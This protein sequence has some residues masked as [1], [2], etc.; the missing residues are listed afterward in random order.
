[1]DP[2]VAAAS[3]G[4]P[5]PAAKPMAIAVA[6]SSSP[7]P[8]SSAAA[9]AACDRVRARQGLGLAGALGHPQLGGDEIAL[10]RRE[11]DE[12]GHAPGH[13]RRRHHRRRDADHDDEDRVPDRAAHDAAQRTVGEVAEPRIDTAAQR[14]G[15]AAGRVAARIAEPDMRQVLGQDQE[16]FDQRQRQHV[17]HHRRHRPDERA[18]RRGQEQQ[19]HE[20][21]DRRHDREQDRPPDPQDAA[22]GR[23]VGPGAVLFQFGID[24][25][26]HYDGVIDHDSQRQDEP[27]EREL[28][29]GGAEELHRR[30]DAGEGD[31]HASRHPRRDAQ[32]EKQQE[33]REDQSRADGAVLHQKVDPALKLLVRVFPDYGGDARGQAVGQLGVQVALH[34]VHDVQ[35]LL[36]PHA[37]D[38]HEHRRLARDRG[39]DVAFG[40]TI[41]HLRDVAQPDLRAGVA[42]EQQL[43]AEGV[44]GLRLAQHA[45]L[46]IALPGVEPPRGQVQVAAPDAVGQVGQPDAVVGEAVA[47]Y[48]D[49]DLVGGHA[50]DLDL[51]DALPVGQ[52][53]AHLLG[54]RLERGADAVAVEHQLDGQFGGLDLGDAGLQGGVGKGGDA[55]DVGLDVVLHRTGVGPA[56]QLGCDHAHPAPG[57]GL[58]LAHALQPLKLFLDGREDG[59]G[60]LGGRGAGI[61]HGDRDR[62][63]GDLGEGADGQV[64]AA[65]TPAATSAAI[66]R[67]PATALCRNQRIRADINRPSA[68]RATRFGNSGHVRA[69]PV[70]RR[71]RRPGR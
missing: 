58:Q 46:E 7:A 25:L 38:R 69:A 4:P 64:N 52:V 51:A 33:H 36:G 57:G 62:A 63:G 60:H 1:M 6:R 50:R 30:E 16:A 10:D 45:Q 2:P 55:R 9:R 8:I 11:E 35:H 44:G 22:L 31:H 15:R 56:G 41:G 66:S 61:G 47:R 29:D 24:V 19:R 68:R 65:A 67:F 23:L 43:V 53:A 40:E 32:V 26:A 17:D 59:V 12:A 20:G 27:E 42:G 28:V 37:V 49:V 14:L 54:Q 70:C 5:P 18:R 71:R 34:L 3:P 48:G 21:Q 13:Q 39:G